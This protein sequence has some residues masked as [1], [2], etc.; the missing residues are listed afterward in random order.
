MIGSVHVDAV[1][2]LLIAVATAPAERVLGEAFNAT[3]GRVIT[4]TMYA[5]LVAKILG[6]EVKIEYVPFSVLE[7]VEWPKDLS[8]YPYIPEG[9]AFFSSEKAEKILG[10]Q[11]LH[12]YESGLRSAYNWW[13]QQERKTPNY[14]IEDLLIQYLH[15]ADEEKTAI[16]TAL[17]REFA[18]RTT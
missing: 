12:D 16:K 18:N 10:Y 6:K 11:H 2:S 5:K 13:Q 1:A 7:E 15:S 14:I 3:R 17:Q 8:L 4:G 9:G